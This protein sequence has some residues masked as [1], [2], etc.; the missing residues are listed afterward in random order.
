[1]ISHE[2]NMPPGNELT[3]FELSVRPVK[4]ELL[5]QNQNPLGKTATGFLFEEHGQQWLYTCWHV[6]TGFN[7]FD[8]EVRAPPNR[9]YIKVTWKQVLFPEPGRTTL[10]DIEEQVVPL[11]EDETPRWLQEE[12]DR[13]HADL[14]SIGL[15]VP[16]T[17]DLIALPIGIKRQER[18]FRCYTPA[19]VSSAGYQNGQQVVITGYPWG[20]SALEDLTPEPIFLTRHIASWVMKARAHSFLVDGVGAA[21]MSGSPV[22]VRETGGFKLIG[23]YTGARFPDRQQTGQPQ[24]AYSGLGEV[25]RFGARNFFQC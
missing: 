2:T 4:V 13:P 25:V 23:V 8:I 24:D 20:Y 6:I 19:D 16:A 14:N 18:R 22:F 10:G 5:D 12:V 17:T 11:Y 9:H 1:M 7:P 15:K 21:G 3:E